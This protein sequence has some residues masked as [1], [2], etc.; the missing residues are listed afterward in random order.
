M[1][2]VVTHNP[3]ETDDSQATSVTVVEK[4][5]FSEDGFASEDNTP[6]ARILW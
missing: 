4:G 5:T 2:R 1:L 3:P 6:E